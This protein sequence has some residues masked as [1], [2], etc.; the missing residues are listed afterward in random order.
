MFYSDW[1]QYE[2]YVMKSLE[3]A[4]I[5]DSTLLA[6][7]DDAMK[8]D[9]FLD[10]VLEHYI[11]THRVDEAVLA[12]NQVY[13]CRTQSFSEVTILG[14]DAASKIERMALHLFKSVLKDAP[15]STAPIFP[16]GL[17]KLFEG[18]LHNLRFPVF[19]SLFLVLPL[20]QDHR[21]ESISQLTKLVVDNM[22]RFAHKLDHDFFR[23]FI[24]HMPHMLDKG[25]TE[26]VVQAT[27]EVLLS[28]GHHHNS[29]KE[30]MRATGRKL[31]DVLKGY[32]Q[33]VQR[34]PLE[35]TSTQDIPYSLVAQECLRVA[36]ERNLEWIKELKAKVQE[37]ETQVQA[38]K[39]IN[40]QQ[41]RE[42][43]PAIY[44]EIE[45]LQVEIKSRGTKNDGYEQWR[46]R[47]SSMQAACQSEESLQDYTKKV[48]YNV[49]AVD[50][51]LVHLDKS[52][53][54]R[55]SDLFFT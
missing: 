51:G 1:Q 41:A 48:N 47:L 5:S 38:L 53:V 4:P 33:G 3:M 16:E 30:Q 50:F 55:F 9:G 31:Y 25:N 22:R 20:F 43:V 37:K 49:I 44:K 39:Q 34:L 7:V 52:D 8:D 46:R 42:E 13:Q 54:F 24:K 27:F 6:A 11:K 26:E 2:H 17:V 19:K 29:D 35:T 45:K 15:L 14:E 28:C 21:N 40:N 12:L 23:D 18:L 32:K 10:D 36:L